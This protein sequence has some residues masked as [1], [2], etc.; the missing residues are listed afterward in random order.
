VP[1]AR[2]C[3]SSQLPAHAKLSAH[4]RFS[5]ATAQFL[6][7]AQPACCGRGPPRCQAALSARSRPLACV[8]AHPGHSCPA[9][10]LLLFPALAPPRALLVFPARSHELRSACSRSVASR[11]MC[12]TLPCRRTPTPSISSSPL[13]RS[14]FRR[15][16]LCP[17]RRARCGRHRHAA[18]LAWPSNLLCSSRPNSLALVPLCSRATQYRIVILLAVSFVVI[19]GHY[20]TP[21]HHVYICVCHRRQVPFVVASPACVWE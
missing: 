2:S 6:L 12:S 11:S 17:G 10:P 8:P 21:W 16:L 7:G 4:R 9:R 14:P 13:C 18:R 15:P 3:P 20:S 19:A 5:S 1:S